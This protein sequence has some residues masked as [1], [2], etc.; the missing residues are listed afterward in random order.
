MICRVSRAGTASAGARGVPWF[1]DGIFMCRHAERR[2]ALLT[3]HR[4]RIF[5]FVVSCATAFPCPD[6]WPR[7][8]CWRRA[9]PSCH[10][11]DVTAADGARIFIAAGS[12]PAEAEIVADHLVEANLRGHDSHGVGMIPAI[13]ASSPTA[14]WFP[15]GAGG[16]AGGRRD[17]DL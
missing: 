7:E 14:R 6:R 13:C 4:F 8:E 9:G 11:R 5:L 1:P 15:T 17:H 3:A 10:P 2:Q 12:T 16:S